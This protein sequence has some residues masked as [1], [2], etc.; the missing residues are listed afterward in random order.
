MG[1]DG[2]LCSSP[3]T[4][5]SGSAAY[6]NGARTGGGPR[7]GGWFFILAAGDGMG[8]VGGV[9]QGRRGGGGPPHKPL[10]LLYA[11]GHFQ[12]AGDAPIRF[13]KAEDQLDL[14]L[15]EFGPPR[16]STMAY[17]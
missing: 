2:D 17:P 16:R 8:G 5:S 14:L 1:T 4:G 12:R 6:G 10:L 13:R 3:W 9:R 7:G 11:L 15:Q